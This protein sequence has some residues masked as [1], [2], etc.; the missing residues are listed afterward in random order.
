M[1]LYRFALIS[2]HHSAGQKKQTF[3]SAESEKFLN[4]SGACFIW[5]DEY[6]AEIM[7]SDTDI[8]DMK[9]EKTGMRADR[10]NSQCVERGW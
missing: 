5:K 2:S 7:Q 8:P 4:F 1:F 10:G 6:D 9:K 3:S